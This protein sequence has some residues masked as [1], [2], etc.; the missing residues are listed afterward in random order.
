MAIAFNAATENVRTGTT[1]PQTFSH[2]GAATIKGVAVLIVHGASS[3]DHIS[4]V[5]YGG[6]A[7]TSAENSGVNDNSVHTIGGRGS[8]DPIEDWTIAL[9]GAYQAG[10]FMI[11][12]QTNERDRSAWAIDVMLECRYF[13][14]DYSGGCV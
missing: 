14:D 12:N 4:A 1:S 2:A 8:F 13:Q 3:T 5:S 10:Q 11:S 6:I 9:E 7:L